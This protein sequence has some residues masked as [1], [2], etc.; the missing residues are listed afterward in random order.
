MIMS[1]FLGNIDMTPLQ[2]KRQVGD[3]LGYYCLSVSMGFGFLRVL[4]Q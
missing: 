4:V 2:K 1:T 3:R